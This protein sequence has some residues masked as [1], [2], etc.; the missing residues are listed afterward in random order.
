MKRSAVSLLAASLLLL[1]ALS[2][3]EH[4]DTQLGA[5]LADQEIVV[6]GHDQRDATLH[7]EAASGVVLVQCPECVLDK[8]QTGAEE[9]AKPSVAVGPSEGRVRSEDSASRSLESSASGPARAPPRI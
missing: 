8:R 3:L 2:A 7:I 1:P 9:Q 4:T 5:R 6:T